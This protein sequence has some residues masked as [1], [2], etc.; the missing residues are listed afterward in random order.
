MKNT[1]KIFLISFTALIFY[2]LFFNA[3]PFTDAQSGVNK[4][5][6]GFA[7]AGISQT[8]G[9][10]G[11]PGWISMNED[12]PNEPPVYSVDIDS[13]GNLT[14]YAWA[15]PHDSTAN[16]RNFGWLK[17]GGLSGFPSG[18]GTTAANARIAGNNIVGWARFC[19]ATQNAVSSNL[20]GNC[21]TMATNLNSGGWDGWV[22]FQG[23]AMNGGNQTGNYGVT[24]SLP[25]A[26]GERFLSGF[27]WGGPVNVGWIDMSSVYFKDKT[28]TKVDFTVAGTTTT[29]LMP[30]AS[31][32]VTSGSAIGISWNLSNVSG[33]VADGDWVNTS[34]GMSYLPRDSTD[35]N[36]IWPTPPSFTNTTA[37]PI[38]KYF[39][40]TCQGDEFDT[41]TIMSIIREVTVTIM[42]GG[43]VASVAVIANPMSVPTFTGLSETNLTWTGTNIIS[44]SCIGIVTHKG[45]LGLNVLIPNAKWTTPPF[46]FLGTSG[47]SNNV[48]FV[49]NVV[50][51]ENIF[52]LACKKAPGATGPAC[53]GDPTLVCGSAKVTRK[54]VSALQLTA[55]IDGNPNSA[56]I[57]SVANPTDKITLKWHSI[58]NDELDCSASGASSMPSTNWSGPKTDLG[59]ANSFTASENGISVMPATTTYYLTCAD[60]NNPNQVHS[61][62][63]Q[64]SVAGT[65]ALQLSLTAVDKADN[66]SDVGVGGLVKIS[67]KKLDGDFVLNSC[68]ARTYTPPVSPSNIFNTNW[69]TMSSNNLNPDK[70]ISN[71][72][73]GSA[74]AGTQLIYEITCNDKLNG[75]PVSAQDMITVVPVIN[76]NPNI[77]I[78]LSANRS[79]IESGEDFELNISSGS[80]TPPTNN[81]FVSC[82]TTGPGPNIWDNFSGSYLNSLNLGGAVIPISYG[83]HNTAVP[84][85]GALNYSITCE[86]SLGATVTDT[87]MVIVSEECITPSDPPGGAGN[88]KPIIIEQ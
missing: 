73:I 52:R 1:K 14:G 53:G 21:S 12:G 4:S 49:G 50:N 66:D 5:L 43:N 74:T 28:K 40:I 42:P 76:V 54:L 33:C 72:T 27:A 2:A 44:G 3:I 36:H 56:P 48:P 38:Q 71:I 23:D 60:K 58:L 67:I 47:F 22:S 83:D 19:S 45:S 16:S 70:T 37:S 39:S 31:A 69:N 17:F 25:N 75:L 55:H 34:G 62:S 84:P 51:D 29:K 30:S 11:G 88:I 24:V 7:W 87:A 61:A 9:N 57:N 32:I 59:V 26:Q 13:S 81:D 20:P 80:V 41:G 46:S 15:N 6:F 65:D 10:P 77:N 64:V 86:D 82:S 85:G 35:G 18:S 79:C 63:T 78:D 8:N 68:I